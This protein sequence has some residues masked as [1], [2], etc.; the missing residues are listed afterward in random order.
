MVGD[1]FW[2]GM[3]GLAI[4]TAVSRLRARGVYLS[5]LYLGMLAVWTLEAVV[6]MVPQ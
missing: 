1:I 2:R 3:Q 6:T 4:L 5:R